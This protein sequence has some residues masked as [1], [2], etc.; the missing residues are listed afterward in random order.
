MVNETNMHPFPQIKIKYGS[1]TYFEGM[2][3]FL[4]FTLRR[5]EPPL[6][7]NVMLTNNFLFFSLNQ[8]HI[9]TCK[10]QTNKNLLTHI[11]H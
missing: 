10:K 7:Q 2:E 9:F 3:N 1:R 6:K 8:A 11:K 4:S 5:I